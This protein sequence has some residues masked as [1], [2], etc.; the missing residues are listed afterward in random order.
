MACCNSCGSST[1]C[2]CSSTPF[3][4]TADVCAEDHTQTIYQAQYAYSICPDVSWNVPVCGGAA[5]LSV[6]GIIG[7]TI[8]AYIWHPAYGFF[9]ITSVNAKTG[10]VGIINSCV[11]GNASPG[12]QIP[13]CTCFIV[14]IPPAGAAQAT[15]LY[16]YVAVDF[17]APAVGDCLDITV[18]T[19]I[20][21]QVG[22]IISIGTGFYEIDAFVSPTVI[23]ICNTGDGMLAGTAVIAQDAFGNYQYPISVVSNCCSTIDATIAAAFDALYCKVEKVTA[24]TVAAGA[25]VT[26]LATAPLNIV[27]TNPSTTRSMKVSLSYI[28]T[29]FA[30]VT[31]DDPV[32]YGQLDIDLQT[33]LNGATYASVLP[34]LLRQSFI[35]IYEISDTIV[36]DDTVIVPPSTGY[37]LDIVGSIAATN[38]AAGDRIAAAS[39]INATIKAM[40]VSI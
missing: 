24:P 28:V 5:L 9:Q 33:S 6:P 26:S 36:F 12:T 37:T 16:P 30:V 2:N 21:L 18:T 40:Q 39:N 4:S 38:S 8:G 1:G 32:E 7:I 34:F 20:G 27:L 11:A 10:K 22:D 29:Y 13:K 23:R 3:Y 19:S 25:P 14:T 17:T 15:N 35:N 31:V